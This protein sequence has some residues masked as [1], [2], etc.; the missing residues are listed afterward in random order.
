MPRSISSSSTRSRPSPPSRSALL[1]TH[2]DIADRIAR[3]RNLGGLALVAAAAFDLQAH[4]GGRG[5]AP[6]NTLAAFRT[7]ARR[8]ASPRSRPISPSPR[9]TSWSSA[10]TRCSIPT[11]CAGPTAQWLGAAGPTIH[12][13]TLAELKRYDIGRLN[14][15]SQYAPA[16]SRAEA[17]RRRTLPD[18]GGVLRRWRAGRALQHRDQDR[19]DQA[20]PHGRSR[21]ASRNWPSRRSGRA[22]RAGA[23]RSS[24][25]TGAP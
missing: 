9:T 12:S 17:G 7:A 1:A 25:S 8:S 4:R 3:L 11:W 15:A 14:P 2:P 16:V 20:R 18:A 19:P 21:R 13:L 10:T 24:R 22:R 5:L 6:E 23:A